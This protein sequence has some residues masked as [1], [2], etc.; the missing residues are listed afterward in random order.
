MA[1]V[2]GH[3]IGSALGMVAC[4]AYARAALATETD[5]RK[6][7]GRL[8]QLL[9]GDLPSGKFVTLV[10]GL[11]IPQDATLHLISAGHGPLLFYS[12]EEKS[13]RRHDAQ[14]PPLGILP[15]FNYGDA[16]I[17]KFAPG[18]ILLLVTD[19]FV[20][21]ANAEDEDFGQHRLEEVISAYRDMPSAR[22]IAELY[23]S[24]VKFANSTPQPDDLTVVVVKRV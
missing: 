8:N 19:G 23:S 10:V 14:G 1:D 13:F 16:Q 18:D 12:S 11:L 9:C 3:G 21:W 17:V 5:L 2:T 24:V 15:H 6:F 20:E 7:L 22:I 4:R